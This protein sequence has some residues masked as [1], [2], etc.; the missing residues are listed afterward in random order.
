S[1]CKITG[2]SADVKIYL[3]RPWRDFAQ[4]TFLNTNMSE[5]VRPMGWNNWDR[6]ERERTSRYS[7]FGSTGPGSK[8]NDR[9]GWAKP[10]S[11]ADVSSISVAAVLGG[12]DNWDPRRV[13][14]QSSRVKVIESPL[15]S[16]PGIGEPIAV[17]VIPLWPEGAPGAKPNAGPELSVDGR[18]S[19]VHAPTLTYFPASAA[20]SVGTA[21]GICPCGGRLRVSLQKGGT[22]VDE[23]LNTS[24]DSVVNIGLPIT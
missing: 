17:Q 9:A 16:A 8:P 11:A 12:T 10:L 5:V 3:G 1:D 15:P 4:V 23:R 13:P 6:P 22:G 20:V 21:G 18:I 19:N 7:E 14:V 2:E 24:G